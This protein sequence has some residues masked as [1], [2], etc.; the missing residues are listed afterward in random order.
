[1][2]RVLL[3]LC[4]DDGMQSLPCDIALIPDQLLANRAIATSNGFKQFGSL[5]VLEDG[6][7]YPHV[8][9]YMLQL[10]VDDLQKV[11]GAL[12][13][14]A[15]VHTPLL[16]DAEQYVQNE[17]Y[18]DASYPNTPEIV[19]LQRDVIAALNPIRDGVREK[20][21]IHMLEDEG[22]ALENLQEYGYRYVGELFRPHLTLTR[23]SSDDTAALNTLDKVSDS[24]G[25]FAKLGIFEMGDN[26]T[27]IRKLA[28]I[29]LLSSSTS[30]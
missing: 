5:F 12:E 17:G 14:I 15:R 13:A 25:V 3:G 28:E 26:G 23:L 10:K 9:L 21:K 4:Y 30:R 20:D 2:V 19:S 6:R 24:S 7:I 16:L 29:E 11:E 22:L 8:S 18:I 1:M 27:A